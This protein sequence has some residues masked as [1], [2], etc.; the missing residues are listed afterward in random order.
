LS[1]LTINDYEKLLNFNF[2]INKDYSDFIN[3]TLTALIDFFD[4]KLTAYA[5]FDVN[6]DGQRSLSKLETL[7]LRPSILKAYKENFYAYDPF[8]NKIDTL[9]NSNEFKYVYTTNDLCYDEFL[10][11]PYGESLMKNGIAYQAILG[12]SDAAH[13]PMHIISIFKTEKEGNFTPKELELLSQIGRVFHK[14]MSLFRKYTSQVDKI[15]LANRL[16]DLTSVGFVFF[17]KSKDVIDFNKTF[18]NY[19]A[20]LSNKP[21]INEI[22]YD[23]INFVESTNQITLDTLKENSIIKTNGFLVTFFPPQINQNQYIETFYCLTIKKIEERQPGDDIQNQ[24]VEEYNLTKRESEILSL[25]VDGASNLQISETVYISVSTV[26]SHVRNIFNKLNV[27]TRS[28]A[29]RKIRKLAIFE[30]DNNN[31]S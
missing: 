3:R 29:I 13:P 15:F 19:S 25:L 18:I 2:F 6:P 23:F 17:N 9:R 16:F 21:N 12:A 14:S 5:V 31:S 4:F 24:L 27:S 26:K 20:F 1:L 22:V 28:E 30:N 8:Y 7:Y 11:S 10:N